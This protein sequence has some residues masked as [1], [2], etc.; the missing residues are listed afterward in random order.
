MVHDVLEQFK[1]LC[2][3]LLKNNIDATIAEVQ[4]RGNVIRV[5]HQEVIPR[6]LQLTH[7]NNDLLVMTHEKIW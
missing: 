3:E 7:G 6:S 4:W 5:S 2:P 1:W